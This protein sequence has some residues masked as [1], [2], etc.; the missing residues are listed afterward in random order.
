MR[1]TISS[2]KQI[3]NFKYLQMRLDGPSKLVFNVCS[4][5]VNVQRTMLLT[6]SYCVNCV[7]YE[8]DYF[9]K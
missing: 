3:H 1:I 6:G 4:L 9:Y 8:R 5:F 2:S 7:F